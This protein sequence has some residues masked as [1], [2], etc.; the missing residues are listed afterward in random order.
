[1]SEP[2]PSLRPA[3]PWRLASAAVISSVSA[4]SR[5]FL[6]GLNNVQVN[7]LENLLGVLD[8]RRKPGGRSRGLLTVCNHVAVYELD[9]T[10]LL[11][12]PPHQLLLSHCR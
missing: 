2:A 4:I 9:F 12:L 7:G 1:M 6:Y 5:A 8:Q 3:L 11:H 10:F